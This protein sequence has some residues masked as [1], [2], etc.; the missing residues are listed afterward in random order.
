MAYLS[1]SENARGLEEGACS[2]WVEAVTAAAEA[3]RF[4][5]FGCRGLKTIGCPLNKGG[6]VGEYGGSEAIYYNG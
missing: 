3:T 5:V 4:A 6:D 1:A 2:T